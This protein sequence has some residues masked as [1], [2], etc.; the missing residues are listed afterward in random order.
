ML[1]MDV[2]YCGLSALISLFSALGYAVIDRSSTPSSVEHYPKR[3]F[4][5][6]IVSDS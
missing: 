4:I 5:R 1:S 2:G 3:D 6:V